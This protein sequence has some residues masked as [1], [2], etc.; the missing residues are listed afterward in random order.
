MET[1]VKFNLEISQ[2]PEAVRLEAEK[3]AKEAYI[4]TLLRHHEIS[5][6]RAA[7][8]LSIPR[9]E[10]IDLMSKYDISPFPD[11]TREELEREVAETL[12]MLE[13]YKK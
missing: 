5:S 1:E 12:L 11:Q 10:L 4:M 6:G 7:E 9:V 2:I 3:K 13:K 8:M